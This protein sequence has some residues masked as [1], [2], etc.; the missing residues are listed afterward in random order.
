MMVSAEQRSGPRPAR[1]P[2][3]GFALRRFRIQGREDFLDDVGILVTGDASH[4]PATARKGLEINAKDSFPVSALGPTSASRP[5]PLTG[6][7]GSPD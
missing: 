3:L 2:P 4:R 7:S 1:W 6:R 5:L